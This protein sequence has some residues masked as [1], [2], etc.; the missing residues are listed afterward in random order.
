MI[1][2]S[3]DI[4]Q[5]SSQEYEV[6]LDTCLVVAHNVLE[7]VEQKIGETVNLSISL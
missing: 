1:I 4:Q 3:V 7:K 2:Y 6:D 5:K